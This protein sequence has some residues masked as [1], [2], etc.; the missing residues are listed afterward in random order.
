[1]LKVACFCVLSVV[2]SGAA[3]AA[4]R[5]AGK[6]IVDKNCSKCHVKADRKGQDAAA[7]ES[8]IK[9]VVAGKT[10]HK[11]KLTLTDAEIAD[12]AAYWV[13]D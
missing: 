8:A 2:A 10:K 11:K 1:M 3:I 9:N 5:A 7:L 13:K 12:V 6:S 4:D